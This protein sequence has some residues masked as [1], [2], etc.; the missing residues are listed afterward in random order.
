MKKNNQ[1]CHCIKNDV[2]I[3]KKFRLSAMNIQPYCIILGNTETLQN[4]N[5]LDTKR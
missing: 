5:N 2:H 1:K 4:F 3:K